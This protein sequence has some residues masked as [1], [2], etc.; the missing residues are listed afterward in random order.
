MELHPNQKRVAAYCRV[1]TDNDDQLNSFEN[2]VSEW[3]Q[4]LENDP[5]VI[6]VD[7]YCDEGI[8]GTSLEG[9]IRDAKKGLIDKIVTKSISRFARNIQTSIDVAR[10]LKEIGVEIYFDNEHLSTLDP[11][12]EVLLPYARL[13][14]KK[15]VDIYPI[16]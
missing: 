14:R 5:N 6:L 13:W 4:R 1:S 15:R 12:S 8:S 9:M 7:I 2:Q 16:T 11:S 3:K 10:E